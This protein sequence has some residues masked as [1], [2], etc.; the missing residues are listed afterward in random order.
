MS[1]LDER[2]YDQYDTPEASSVKYV[3]F[4]FAAGVIIA[5]AIG[6]Y[7][8]AS[9]LIIDSEIYLILL[10][11]FLVPMVCLLTFTACA[12]ARG[13][14]IVRTDFREDAMIFEEMHL[15]ASRAQPMEGTDW[16]RCPECT[17]AFELSNAKPV[18]EKVVQCPFCDSRLIVG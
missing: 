14:S 15:R 18:D 12:W 16:Y 9:V 6:L 11:S 3:K 17:E 10:L 4:V 8:S 5:A 1:K 2:S 7:Y 13:T